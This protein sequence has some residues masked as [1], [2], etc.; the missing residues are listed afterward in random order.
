[1]TLTATPARIMLVQLDS[2]GMWR[3]RDE[4]TLER[5]GYFACRADALEALEAAGYVLVLQN[6]IGSSW[7]RG[8]QYRGI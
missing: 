7:E 8:P 3:A 4:N 5:V 6:A 1:M 2:T